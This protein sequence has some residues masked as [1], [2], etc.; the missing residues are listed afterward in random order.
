MAWLY[1][2]L[3]VLAGLAGAVLL[4]L[5]TIR[6]LGRREPYAAFLR[7]PNRRKL[8]F[9]RSLLRDGR[10]PL[11]VKLLPLAVAVYFASPIDLIPGI[12]LDDVAFALL[13]LVLII[14]LTSRPVLDDL[15]EQAGQADGPNSSSDYSGEGQA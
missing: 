15:I 12:M 4:C 13:A 5:W 14:R 2:A 7:L 10:V 11:Y 9:F 1:L 8:T 6:W 3:S